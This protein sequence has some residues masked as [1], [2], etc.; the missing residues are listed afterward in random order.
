MADAADSPPNRSRVI[1]ASRH[2]GDPDGDVGPGQAETDSQLIQR[3]SMGVSLLAALAIAVHLIWPNLKI[4]LVTVVLLIFGSLPWLRGIVKSISLPGGPSID[5]RDDRLRI[6][7]R[8]E[9]QKDAAVEAVGSAANTATPSERV[10]EIERQAELY[11]KI[12]REMPSGTARTSEMGK[13]AQQILSLLPVPELDVAHRLLS[14]RAG[15][16]LVAY[17][18][19]VA[20][21]DADRG[22]ELIETLTEREGIPYNQS[23]ALRALNRILD[24]NGSGWVSPR[25]VAMLSGMLDGLRRGSSRQLMLVNLVDR[26]TGAT[27][28]V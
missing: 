20:Q 18:S 21:P 16:R 7:A 6:I 24:L 1:M 3:V 15:Q 10:Q 8:E 27:G 13:V 4:D 22:E 23:W 17:L 25:S 26:L 12:R 14:P 28:D 9:K 2:G 5:L 11:E 19:L